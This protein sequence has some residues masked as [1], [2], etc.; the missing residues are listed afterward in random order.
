MIRQDQVVCRNP[1]LSAYTL[2][3]IIG[4]VRE[5]LIVAIPQDMGFPKF[6]KPVDYAASLLVIDTG[7][8]P[9]HDHRDQYK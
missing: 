3:A 2:C 6:R 7:K 9:Q 4:V 1:A 8:K 5:M